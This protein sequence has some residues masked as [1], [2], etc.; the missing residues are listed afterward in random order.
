MNMDSTVILRATTLV[1][2]S[3]TIPRDISLLSTGVDN[4]FYLSMSKKSTPHESLTANKNFVTDIR[5]CPKI[6]EEAKISDPNQSD[7]HDK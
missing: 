7:S 2:P 5:K 4:N 1:N 6:Y 3:S